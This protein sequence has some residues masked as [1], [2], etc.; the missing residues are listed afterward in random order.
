M[1]MINLE[2]LLSSIE[3]IT[4]LTALEEK[5]VELLG[6]NGVITQQLKSLATLSIEEKKIKGQEINVI[7]T[8]ITQKLAEKKDTLEELAL[9]EKL[10]S[11]KIDLTRP[12]Q[13]SNHGK[14]HPLTQTIQEVIA[15]FGQMGFKLETGPEIERDDYNFD[16]LNIPPHHPARQDQDTF[17]MPENSNGEKMVLRTQTSPVQIRTMLTQEL[18]IQII[19]P[20]RT[21][22][23]DSDQTHTPMFHQVE[24]LYIGENIHMGHLKGCL[25]DFLKS[26]FNVEN[27]PIRFR[28][29]YFPFTEPSAEVDIGCHRSEGTL[30][31]GEGQDWLEILG[32]GMVHPQVLINCGVDPDKYQGFAF[33]M[34]IERI[35]MLKYGISDLRTFYEGDEEWINHYGFEFYQM[36]GILN[37]LHGGIGR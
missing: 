32:C 8:Q 30:T 11:E 15:I 16:Y 34:G 24:G 29:S 22:R 28:P 26:F 36:P 3:T 23:S 19:V 6:K 25:E 18:P 37:R 12:V 10:A 7:K 5:R 13:T 2:D 9:K 31:I 20:G 21:F 4:C 35:A 27:L 14:I 17:Y 33:G 1:T